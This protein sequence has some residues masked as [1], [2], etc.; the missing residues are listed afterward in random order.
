MKHY[1]RFVL[2]WL[3]NSLLVYIASALYPTSYVLGTARVSSAIAPFVAGLG[4]TLICKLGKIALSKLGVALK[5]RYAKFVYYWAVNTVA[6]WILAR[7]APYSGLGIAAYY[8]A[9]FL[10]FF[11]SLIQWLLRQAFKRSNL[12]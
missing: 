2:I 4:L 10:G 8:W 11:T 1:L 9:I 7:F 3:A 6:I 5:G 12:L